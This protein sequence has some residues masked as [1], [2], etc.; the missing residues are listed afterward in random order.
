MGGKRISGMVSKL[1]HLGQ[2]SYRLYG[3]S[4]GLCRDCMR[5][6]YRCI[7]GLYKGYTRGYMGGALKEHTAEFLALGFLWCQGLGSQHTGRSSWF[8]RA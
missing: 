2:P 4:A 1:E 3:G 7:W 5:V 8:L 6:I